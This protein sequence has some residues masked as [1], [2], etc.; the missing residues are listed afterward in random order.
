[1]PRLHYV[2]DAGGVHKT[3]FGELKKMRHPVTGKRLYWTWCV[4]YFHAAERIT[5]IANALFA[6]AMQAVSWAT[7]RKPYRLA[8]VRLLSERA[9][10]DKA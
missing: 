1:M 6:D 2:T 8:K 10:G 7:A 3:F 4:D 5:T 9:L